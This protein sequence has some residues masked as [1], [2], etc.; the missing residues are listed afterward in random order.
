MIQAPK[1]FI[2]ETDH[3]WVIGEEPSDSSDEVYEIR[4]SK[5]DG[6]TYCSH[7]TW[8][9]TL[10]DWWVRKGHKRGVCKHM[11]RF[12]AKQTKLVKEAVVEAA[13]VLLYDLE[14]WAVAKRAIVTDKAGKLKDEVKVRRPGC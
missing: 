14:T 5:R 8:Y 1:K 3:Y 10:H 11:D 7:S 13:E 9:Q 12:F 6:R 4:T 2:R